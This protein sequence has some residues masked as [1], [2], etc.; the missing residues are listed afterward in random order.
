MQLTIYLPAK[1]VKKIYLQRARYKSFPHDPLL[2]DLGTRL[3]RFMQPYYFCSSS[4]HIVEGFVVG[5][6]FFLLCLNIIIFNNFS[7]NTR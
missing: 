1:N 3:P 2:Y 6:F 7:S 5:L 4:V